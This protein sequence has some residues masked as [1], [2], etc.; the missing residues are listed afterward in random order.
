M[1]LMSIETLF[2]SGNINSKIKQDKDWN[3]TKYFAAAPACVFYKFYLILVP[4]TLGYL[5]FIS[6]K[7]FKTMIF[8]DA[9]IINKYIFRF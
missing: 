1:Y 6:F 5:N 2:W 9:Y 7:L 4:N 8:K 3:L